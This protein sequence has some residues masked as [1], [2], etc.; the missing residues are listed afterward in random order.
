MRHISNRRRIATLLIAFVA[1]FVGVGPAYAGVSWCR[2]DPVVRLDGK[3]VQILV[4]IPEQYQTL[5]NGP[6]EIELRTPKGLPRELLYL[7][8]GFNGMGEDFSFGNLSN[9]YMDHDSFWIKLEVRVP[10]QTSDTVPVQVEVIQENGQVS[11][12]YGTH[13]ETEFMMEL[14]R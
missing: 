5:V 8:E 7:D 10:I 12:F 9:D 3:Q 13:K 11:V 14:P 6:T 4:G 2:T 1:M